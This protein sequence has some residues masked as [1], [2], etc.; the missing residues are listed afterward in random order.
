MGGGS[1]SSSSNK[2]QSSSFTVG[3]NDG[4]IIGDGSEYFL[5]EDNSVTDNSSW[6]DNSDRSFTDNSDRSFTDNSSWADNSDRSFTDNSDRSFTDKSDN[7]FT[8]NSSWADNSDRSFTDNSD[9]S[10][11]DSSDR[12]F[13]DNSDNSFTDNSR[14]DNSITDYS[15]R[16]FTD[17]SDNSITEIDGGVVA[18][19]GQVVSE[20][21]LTV[22]DSVARQTQVAETA[23]SRVNDT[24]NSAM[25]FTSDIASR[26]VQ[27]AEFMSMENTKFLGGVSDSLNSTFR[28]INQTNAALFSQLGNSY[29]ENL[30]TVERATDTALSVAG[31][32]SR[33][34]DAMQTESVVKWASLAAAAVGVA[35]ALRT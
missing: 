12:S 27:G 11:S 13:T 26:A 33:S 29:T 28:D 22:S 10:F 34:D 16:S 9:N 31:N 23:I 17:N 21:L 8:D 20:S 4:T 14:T 24:A 25:G 18:M 2:T 7:S 30:R 1:K 35:A 6:T 5:N 15:D 19:A 32:V 3:E